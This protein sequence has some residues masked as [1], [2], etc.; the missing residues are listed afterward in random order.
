MSC[1]KEYSYEGGPQARYVIEGSPG[2]CAPIALSGFYIAGTATGTGNTLQLT[3]NVTNTG[4]YT[5]FTTPRDGISFAASGNFADTGIHVVT[6]QCSGIPDSAGSFTLK[7]P[8]DN[9][10]NFNLNVLKKGP[11]GYTLAGGPNDCSNPVIGGTFAVGADMKPTNT[12]TLGV[13]VNKPGD[14]A[15]NTDTINGLSFSATGH[16]DAAGQQ[17]VILK[18]NGKPEAPGLLYFNVKADSSRCSFG[19]PVQSAEPLATYVLQ[20]GI[21]P[22]GLICSPQ[23][24]EGACIAGVPLN[25]SNTITIAPYATIPGNYSISTARINGIIFSASGNFPTAGVYSVMLKGSGTPL[26]SGTFTFTPYIVGPAPIGG[27]SCDVP[28]TIQ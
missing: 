9:G 8:G 7:I 24:I 1:R 19:V 15:I 11:A 6:L 27:S 23:S 14:Y 17:T 5:I 20:S 16:F 21:G 4:N 13:I 2:E 10:C 12:V 22:S 26:A 28:L 25:S 18:G 3:I